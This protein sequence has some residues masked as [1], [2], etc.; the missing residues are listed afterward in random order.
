MFWF[1]WFS[2]FYRLS[3]D[4]RFEK[5]PSFKGFVEI[6][7]RQRCERRQM[8][9]RF[10]DCWRF[11]LLRSDWRRLGGLATLE[12]QR[13]HRLLLWH[14]LLLRRRGFGQLDIRKGVLQRLREFE[15][16]LISVRGVFR[17]RARKG[18]TKHFHARV[19]QLAKTVG[20]FT[21]LGRKP[22][23]PQQLV[24]ERRK[25]EHVCLTIPGSARPP[26][27]SG[28]RTANRGRDSDFLE[29]ARN[30]DARQPRF[31]VR[32]QHVARMQGAVI[33]VR[34]RGEIQRAGELNGDAKRIGG[35]RGAVL[36]H[37][38]IE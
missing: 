17:Q 32:Q 34:D 18:P 36:A 15:R 31:I 35:R 2:G 23:P 19:R 13:R 26:L 28:I 12:R 27:G 8:F 21:S 38:E 37:R 11:G 9:Q 7:R 1:C 24:D 3:P 14:V 6:Q 29:G 33:D 10:I 4:E 22:T 5:F 30:A 25:A 20:R 16:R